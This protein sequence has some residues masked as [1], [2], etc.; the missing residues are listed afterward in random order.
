MTYTSIHQTFNTPAGALAVP[1]FTGRC[2][3]QNGLSLGLPWIYTA[4]WWSKEPRLTVQGITWSGSSLH[5]A[6][7]FANPIYSGK[8]LAW[9]GKGGD[10]G[11]HV[12]LAEIRFKPSAS[13]WENVPFHSQKRAQTCELYRLFAKILKEQEDTKQSCRVLSGE[14]GSRLQ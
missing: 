6:T 14:L 11:I 5:L 4:E 10:W 13:D 12:I 2:W 1:G 7:R 8:V 3:N 9:L